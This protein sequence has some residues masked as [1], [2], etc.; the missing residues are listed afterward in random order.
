MRKTSEVYKKIYHYTT[1]NG[2]LEII[3]SQRLWSTHY[4][5]LND[6]SEIIL[7]KKPLIS[8]LYPYVLQSY[9]R[10]VSQYPHILADIKTTGGIHQN[11]KHDTDAFVT[12]QYSATGDEI[13]I[14]SFCG[15]HKEKYINDNG[16]LSQWRAYGVD[17]GCALVFDT[18]EIEEL[19]K[20]EFANYQYNHIHISDLIYSDDKDKLEKELSDDLGVLAMDAIK[21][22]NPDL[23]KGETEETI[24]KGYYSFLRCITRYKHRGF[25][26]ENEVRIVALPSNNLSLDTNNNSS[27][28]DKTILFKSK[29]GLNV[30][31][32]ELFDSDEII[33]PIE[34]IIVGP[35]REKELR[36]KTLEVMLRKTKI[37]I[38]C[39]DIPY[40]S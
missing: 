34:K 16:L 33:L 36:A 10:V 7:F 15:E 2:V 20:Y 23:W 31:Y 9:E 26:E 24:L 19:C 35:H 4:K 8:F 21:M 13:Y 32:I 1:W 12:A 39:S 27:K 29:N 5:F 25:K 17:G 22:F 3:K 37:E 18:K 28:K 11:A 14:L 38:M 6:F 40:I 30:P